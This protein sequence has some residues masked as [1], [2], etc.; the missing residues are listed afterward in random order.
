MKY[1]R[2]T[3]LIFLFVLFSVLLTACGSANPKPVNKNTASTPQPLIDSKEE[4]D[5]VEI[6]GV[7]KA[8]NT[9]SKSVTLYD[10]DN[11]VDIVLTYTGG[12]DIRDAHDKMITID[13]LVLGE[14]IEA[15][16]NLSNRKLT[17][18]YI[19]KEAWTYN[20]VNTLSMNQSENI[21]TIAKRKYQFDEQIVITD[22]KKLIGAIDLNQ[23]DELTAKG[24]GSYI[25]SLRVTKGHGHIRITGEDAFIG[26]TIEIG[27]GIILPVKKD[28][29]IVAREGSYRVVLENKGLKATKD[30]KLFRDE[31]IVLDFSKYKPVEEEIGYV[32]FEI[33]PE[34][35]DLYIDEKLINYTEPVKLDYGEYTV[36]VAMTGY[37]DF[38]GVLSIAET[39][40]TVHISLAEQLLEELEDENSSEDNSENNSNENETDED[41]SENNSNENETDEDNSENNSNENETDEDNSENNSNEPG[42]CQ[43]QPRTRS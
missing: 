28:M 6:L 33:E 38:T 7:I 34:G 37:E 42:T 23:K 35:A 12:T 17:Q 30:I 21:I 11:E 10:I 13:Q 29:L 25:Y 32:D 15:S 3:S 18:L 14:I 26:G 39:T 24:I 8:I 40:S 5:S 36:R 4:S 16:Y 43:R 31:E 20:G 2:M 27:Y 41:N 22:G 9:S 1:K 19:H